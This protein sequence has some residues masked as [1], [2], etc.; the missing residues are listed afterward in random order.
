MKMLVMS[1]SHSGLSFMRAAIKCV[2]P[3]V[4]VHLG[5][6]YDDA[7]TI[8]YENPHIPMYHVPGNCDMYRCFGK[9][10][11]MCLTICG[12][13]TFMAHGHTYG[14]KGSTA[15]L[16]AAA[17]EYDAK[18]VLYGHT[19]QSDCRQ[20]DGVWIV[21]PGSCGSYSGSVALIEIDD[22]QVCRCRILTAGAF[23]W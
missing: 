7:E 2:K 15:R 21:N 11:M 3:D 1:D 5:D 23:T 6:H 17:R 18:L 14:V 20:E 9:P 10:E 22:G 8:A 4:L 19:H 13:M 16:L 12:V